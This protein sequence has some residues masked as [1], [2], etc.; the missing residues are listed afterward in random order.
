VGELAQLLHNDLEAPAFRLRPRLQDDKEA[1]LAAGCLGA[2]V[3]GSGPTVV[4]L[5]RDQGSANE[6]AERVRARFDRVVVAASARS[7]VTF[8]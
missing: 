2:V 6:I 7:C 8:L 5:A 3:T 4:G 1:L